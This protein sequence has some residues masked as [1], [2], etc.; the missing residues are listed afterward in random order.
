[1]SPSTCAFPAA[2]TAFTAV[3]FQA[4]TLAADS[5]DALS[6]WPEPAVRA[7]RA[8]PAPAARTTAVRR[9][10]APTRRSLEWCIRCPFLDNASPREARTPPG[11]G[12]RWLHTAPYRAGTP[13][14]LDRASNVEE[15]HVRA[16]ETNGNSPPIRV[17][18]ADDHYLLREGL[19]GLLESR[20]D[21]EVVATCGDL[22]SLLAAVDEH[23]PDVVVTDIRM[24]PSGGDE[25]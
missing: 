24:P 12:L 1:M 20:G 3:T 8:D 15:H 7:E 16:M 25:G 22:D 17:V 18:L 21:V 5:A 10:S 9:T 2:R 13:A 11:G 14:A 6:A 4:R 23:R 19:R